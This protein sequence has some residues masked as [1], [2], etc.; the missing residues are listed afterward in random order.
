MGVDP[1]WGGAFA[2]VDSTGHLV[3][4]IKMKAASLLVPEIKEYKDLVRF[5]L[6]ESVHS[7]PKQGVSSTFKFGRAYGIMEGV[8]AAMLIPYQ[9]ITPAKWQGKMQCRTK[10]DKSITREAARKLFP[11]YHITDKT[12]DAILLA[13]LARR[14]AKEMGWI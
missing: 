5:A 6:I 14:E 12:A 10:G 9:L 13:E 7:M 3:T 11:G 4:S 8:V 2:I 1:G